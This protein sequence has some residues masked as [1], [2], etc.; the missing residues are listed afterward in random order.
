MMRFLCKDCWIA[1]EPATLLARCKRCEANTQIERADPLQSKAASVTATP[2]VCG[3]HPA[4]PLDLYCGTCE[5]SL[6]PRTVVGERSIVAL[7]GDTASGKTS[8][9][10]VLSERLRQSNGAGV[11]I[12]QALGD[13]DEQMMKAIRGI[14]DDG[15]MRATPSTDAG[16]RNYA[17]ELATGASA[18]VM[19]FHDAAGE[20]WNELGDLSRRE[21]ARLYRYL[22]LVGSVIFTIDG[23]RVIEAFDVAARRGVASP[24][25]RAAQVHEISIIDT[26]SRRMRAR[27]ERIPAAVVVTKADVF[28]E[29]KEWALFQ[30]DSG[31]EE[32]A[33][34]SA[35]RELLMKSGR[36][37]LVTALEEA[38]AP[39]R[40]FTV[41]AFGHDPVAPLR[42]EK[43]SPARV[44]EPL[45][46]L[47]GASVH[48]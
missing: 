23:A 11:Y 43:L 17:W 13:S 44:E 4:E 19:A 39:V 34:G 7:L 18:T 33:I 36:Q 26:V 45:M 12:R 22:D 14:L 32:A 28:W 40:F 9:L 29:R 42:V 25:L 5:K 10:W 24:Q 37:A 41:S 27:G 15:R 47:L 16:V 8:F 6:P 46:A 20:V 21:Y 2:L 1:H 35:T 3:L 48:R 38:F 30:E 31:A